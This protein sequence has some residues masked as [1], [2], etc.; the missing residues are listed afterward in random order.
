MTT[1]LATPTR[2]RARLGLRDV[3][4][5]AAFAVTLACTR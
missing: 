3:L 4:A 1:D 2:P 5:L